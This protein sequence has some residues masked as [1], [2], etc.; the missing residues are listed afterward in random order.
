MLGI[1]YPRTFRE[2]AMRGN[3]R[4]AKCLLSVAFG[5]ARFTRVFGSRVVAVVQAPAGD[6]EFLQRQPEHRK[7]QL[8]IAVAGSSL[9]EAPPHNNRRAT[10]DRRSL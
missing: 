4:V 8:Y 1:V 9:R 2:G 5:I 10:R 3:G 6:D 7:E